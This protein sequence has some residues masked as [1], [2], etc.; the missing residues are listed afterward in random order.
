MKQLNAI[1][2]EDSDF[3]PGTER[4]HWQ[5]ALVK[6]ADKASLDAPLVMYRGHIIKNRFGPA[7]ASIE[8]LRPPPPLKVGDTINVRGQTLRIGEVLCPND[9]SS[10]TRP[11]K[12]HE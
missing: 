2:L 12:R 3:L 7:T 5:C 1:I 11:A 10:A 6:E 8:S 4:M 9:P